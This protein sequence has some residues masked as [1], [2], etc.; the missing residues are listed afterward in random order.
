MCASGGHGV[1]T[2]FSEKIKISK[3]KKS[4]IWV[5]FQM[6]DAVKYQNIWFEP[7][8]SPVERFLQCFPYKLPQDKRK[9][10]RMA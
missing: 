8:F 1:Q 5:Y 7:I 4:K 9:R 6:C 3:T 2:V 10:L